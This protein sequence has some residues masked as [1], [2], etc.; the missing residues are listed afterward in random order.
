MPF[1][2]VSPRP[3]KS[4]SSL[5]PHPDPQPG[6][7]CTEQLLPVAPEVAAR[8]VVVG[9]KKLNLNKAASHGPTSA[10]LGLLL[11]APRA[12]VTENTERQD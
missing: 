7:G 10:S 11:E 9:G 5:L 12:P 4:L 6:G 8:V 3:F 1:L 2:L